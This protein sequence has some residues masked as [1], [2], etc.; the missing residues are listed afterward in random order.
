MAE[1]DFDVAAVAEAFG[2]L[3]GEIDG[4]MLAAGAAEGDH[5]MFEAAPAIGGDAGVDEGEDAGEKLVNAFLLIEIVDDGC[6]FAG[7]RFEALFA[8]GIGEAA[9]VEN[10]TA[11]VAGFVLGK[12][13]VKRKTENANGEIFGFGG[14]AEEFFRGEHAAKGVEKSGER[15]GEGDVMEKPAKIF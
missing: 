8:A 12:I 5:E 7:E 9:A 10:E 15:D 2:E 14:E 11:A 6:V 1:S 3:F 13:A 4:A